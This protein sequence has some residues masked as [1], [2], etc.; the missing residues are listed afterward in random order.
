M[1]GSSSSF[2]SRLLP[3]LIVLGLVLGAASPAAGHKQGMRLS[4]GPVVGSSSLVR[5]DKAGVLVL[6][7]FGGG[8]LALALRELRAAD[9]AK[10][11]APGNLLRL[12]LRVNGVPTQVE[13]PFDIR[14]GKGA[15]RSRITPAQTLYK[16]DL[17]ELVSVELLDQVGTRFGAIGVPPGTRTPILSSS[18]IYV[19][20]STSPIRFSRGGDTR[21]KLRD[22]GNF[23]TGFDTLLDA[24][25][26]A[27]SHPGVTVQLDLVR[28]GV[29]APFSYSYDIV[30]GRS[31]PDGR[32]VVHI[33][34]AVTES[35]EVQRLDVND[36]AL[37]RFATLGLKIA[38]PRRPAP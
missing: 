18:L 28:D 13:L 36:S 23:N 21:L 7:P 5:I 30:H 35:V 24:A 32:P 26:E 29:P 3:F 1:A 2:R 16:G 34:L 11:D 37:T 6:R 33:G 15:V 8:K 20:D 27:I 9:G 19:V 12:A 25:G 4:I 10:L 31:V 22:S 38:A 17:V 14:K